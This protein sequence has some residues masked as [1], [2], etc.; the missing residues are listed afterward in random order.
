MVVGMVEVE[1]VVSAAPIAVLAPQLP[2]GLHGLPA[3]LNTFFLRFR[4]PKRTGKKRP[5]S[6][7]NY[8]IF[9]TVSEL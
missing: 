5:V 8:G 4:V 6:G 3:I 2:G 1:I 9:H 7:T